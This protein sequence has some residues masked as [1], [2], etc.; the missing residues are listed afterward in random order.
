[1]AAKKRKRR[2]AKKSAPLITKVS[3]A[4]A[5]TKAA[6][7]ITKGKKALRDMLKSVIDA[8]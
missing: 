1:M 2:V 3:A 6:Q 8:V 5:V 7:S 4:K